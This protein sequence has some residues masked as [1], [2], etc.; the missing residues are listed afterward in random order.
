MLVEIP[1]PPRE[2]MEE[3]RSY[4]EAMLG[5]KP[6]RELVKD[7]VIRAAKARGWNPP[8]E[9]LKA[10]TYYLLRD[11]EGLGKLTP[12][13][14]DPEIEDIK[15]P[16]RGDR[17]L[18]VM[19]SGRTGWLPTNVELTEEEA[20][21]LVLKM[22]ELC[23]KQVSLASPRLEGKLPSGERVQAALGY[24][25]SEGGTTFVIR[26]YVRRE[27]TLRD[28]VKQR[29]I[30]PEAAAYLWLLV[31]EGI[32]GL[33]VGETGSGKTTF[34]SSLLRLIP[35]DKSIIT[36]EDTPEITL[37]HE[38]WIQLVT[39]PGHGSAREI[40]YAD[41]MR[42]VLRMRPD[43]CIVGESRGEETRILAQFIAMG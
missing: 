1:Q 20:R 19:L 10:A 24:E 23:G 22:A 29:A 6:I 30:S 32:S 41:L 37:D 38:N 5:S 33:V 42:D 26:K 36:V 40:G 39:R 12:L 3:L 21:E 9:L 25:V 13:L 27:L 18:W 43:Y 8:R 34:L 7:A 14:K 17:R 31:E 35:W 2:L 15:L 28:W 4:I 11:L 16:S